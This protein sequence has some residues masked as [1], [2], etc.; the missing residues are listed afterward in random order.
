MA[1]AKGTTKLAFDLLV[2]AITLPT[3]AFSM[4]DESPVEED[5]VQEGSRGL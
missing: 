5:Q 3:E 2:N 4:A 1:G